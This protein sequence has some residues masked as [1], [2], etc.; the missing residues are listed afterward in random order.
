MIDKLHLLT[1]QL[2]AV[3]LCIDV[4]SEAQLSECVLQNV[5]N[6]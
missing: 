1:I 4:P 6:I 2:Y 5:R 3:Y